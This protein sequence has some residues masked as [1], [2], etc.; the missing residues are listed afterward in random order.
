M[1]T[2]GIFQGLRVFFIFFE[3]APLMLT[4]QNRELNLAPSSPNCCCKVVN[5]LHLARFGFS[6]TS[7]PRG[8]EKAIFQ[9]EQQL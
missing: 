8:D 2:T 9:K 4:N 3:D 5:V 7:F 6:E 1:Y